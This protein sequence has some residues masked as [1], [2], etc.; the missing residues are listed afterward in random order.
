[1]KKLI[2]ITLVLTSSAIFAQ[3]APTTTPSSSSTRTTGLPGSQPG[4]S[5]T[6]PTQPAKV[7]PREEGPLIKIPA[8]I[9]AP[10]EVNYLSPGIIVNRGA[11]WAG[12]DNLL[13]ISKNI[14]IH[15]ELVLP[16]GKKSPIEEATIKKH[17]A[18]I[19][20]KAGISNQAQAFTNKPPLP[21]FHVLIMV[22]N[23][24]K[25]YAAYVG[26]RLFEEVT[27]PRVVL[28]DNTFFQAITWEKQDLVVASPEEIANQV[29][30]TLDEIAQN[31]ADRY[32]YFENV[33]KDL[34]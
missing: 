13:N 10:E 19:F 9:A 33:K 17:V 18:D 5:S 27:V 7:P 15:L 23:I 14:P 30:T 25:G 32:T 29:L 6:K 20:A 16:V 2:F 28:P 3:T 22:Q 11:S 31:F 8:K 1:M 26:G 21:Y 4:T 34:K 12:G 24:E